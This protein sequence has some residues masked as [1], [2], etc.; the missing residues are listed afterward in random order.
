MNK[1]IR[2]LIKQTGIL[3]IGTFG[4]KVLSFLIVPLYTYTLTTAEYGTIDLFTT[5]VNLMVPF[6]T[7]QIQESMIRYAVGKDYSEKV[8]LTN[9]FV[10][11]GFG[12]LV[13][14]LL[15][16]IYASLFPKYAVLYYILL[17]TNSFVNVFSHYLR[18]AEK[19]L[20]YSLNGII[21]TIFTVSL[22]VLFL[23]V[24]HWGIK[25]YL[26]S[27][28][29]A[30]LIS[31]IYII[32]ASRLFKQIDF[33]L[34]SKKV[35][36]DILKYSIPLIPNT[37]MWWIMNAGDKLIIKIFLGVEYNGI[38]AL[39]MKVPTIIQLLYS[40]FTMAWQ[41]SAFENASDGER[42]SYYNEAF[43]LV[44]FLLSIGTACIIALVKPVFSGLMSDAYITAWRYVPL[45]CVSMTFSCYSSFLG[46]FYNLFK[47]NRKILST[48]AIGAVTNVMTNFILVKFFGLYGIAIGTILGFFV[49]T[50][51]RAS[52]ATRLLQA[53]AISMKKELYSTFIL[54]IESYAVVKFD[55][56]IYWVMSIFC[57]L[58]VIAV[59]SNGIIRNLNGFFR[60]SKSK[61]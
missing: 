44:G 45:L 25:G 5:L 26:Y 58:F 12:L 41:V 17:V 38:Y 32:I 24:Y 19:N 11:F 20:A 14:T 39:S 46:I 53:K 60:D 52:D 51:I 49:M 31:V 23:L 3:A 16:P 28:I 37:L 48:T 30:Q 35:I 10:I 4:S 47:V 7:F 50:F 40:I 1:N 57:I 29:I 6:V 13:A 54:L 2:K 56:K 18:I 8:V 59:Y 22:N 9:C 61:H 43:S 42:N 21:V 15:I 33:K 55:G 27:M 36:Q 34:T